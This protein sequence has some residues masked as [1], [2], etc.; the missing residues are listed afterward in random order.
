MGSRS[1]SGSR[2][3]CSALLTRRSEQIFGIRHCWMRCRMNRECARGTSHTV[4]QMSDAP[5][6][7]TACCLA[8]LTDS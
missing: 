4:A 7:Q 6:P 3:Q 1:A 5:S 8:F 2:A